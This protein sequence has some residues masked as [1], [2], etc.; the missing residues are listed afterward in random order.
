MGERMMID[1]GMEWDV[2]SQF[3]NSAPGQRGMLRSR[4]QCPP[5]DQYHFFVKRI[6][7]GQQL[8]EPEI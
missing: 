4:A 7:I 3:S 8:L 2:S 5:E 6:G 1:H